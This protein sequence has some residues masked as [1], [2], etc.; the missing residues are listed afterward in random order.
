MKKIF[1]ILISLL[2]VA[3]VFGVALTM[4]KFEFAATATPEKVKA[5]ELITVTS[6]DNP[7][8]PENPS[9]YYDPTIKAYD[10][11]IKTL[12]H[13]PY[14]SDSDFEKFQ[15]ASLYATKVSGP[16]EDIDEYEQTIYIWTYRANQAGTI[17]F[18]V[19]AFLKSPP[20]VRGI[21]NPV[22]IES[23]PSYPMNF[24]MKILGFGNK[25]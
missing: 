1:A 14:I 19:P 4:A 22:T 20:N 11:S 16:I 23:K 17:V 5:G 21:S 12:D 2:F 6:W 18:G 13:F 15:D 9:I 25:D 8:D 7:Y 10:P 24:F 3:S